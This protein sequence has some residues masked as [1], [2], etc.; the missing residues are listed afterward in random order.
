[1]F[2]RK[3]GREVRLSVSQSV[4]KGREGS[5]VRRLRG[6]YTG[7]RLHRSRTAEKGDHV[8]VQMQVRARTR[9]RE[10]DEEVGQSGLLAWR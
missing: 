3:Q 7:I 4:R 6:T 10:G 5:S 9:A 1:M 2:G 8:H